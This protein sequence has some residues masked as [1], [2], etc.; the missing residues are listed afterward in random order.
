[1]TRA[2]EAHREVLD[3]LGLADRQ[4]VLQALDEITAPLSRRDIEKALAPA[5]NRQAR[6][7]IVPALLDCFD[8]IAIRRTH[9]ED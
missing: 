6:L 4:A 7:V 9:C 1:M 8:I 5:L 2:W 3:R